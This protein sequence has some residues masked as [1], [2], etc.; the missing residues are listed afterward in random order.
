MMRNFLTRCKLITNP[1]LFTSVDYSDPTA[2]TLNYAPG[3]LGTA[4]ITIRV[5]DTPGLWVEYTF[6]VTTDVNDAPVVTVPGTLQQSD[7]T[8]AVI[9]DVT[10]GNLISVSDDAGTAPVRVTLAATHGTMTLNG[11]AGLTFDPGQDGTADATMTFTGTLVDINNALNGM[12][13]N[14]DAGYF[15]L[16][17][18]TIIVND[19]GN[20]GSGGPQTATTVANISVE[21]YDVW[22]PGFGTEAGWE[23]YNYPAG[24]CSYYTHDYATYWQFVDASA[25]WNFY[26][27]T[28]WVRTDALGNAPYSDGY[29]PY[30]TWFLD[31]VPGGIYNGYDVLYRQRSYEV[32]PGSHGCRS[33]VLAAD[34]R[35]RLVVLRRERLVSDRGIQC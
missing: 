17:D 6:N 23:V 28:A 21:P 1:S 20:T 33:H 2:F 13:F 34:Q 11:V 26:N 3:V 30:A 29:G 32:L 24:G 10:N 22:F 12:S 7:T 9:F 16:A 31:T 25:T 18:V 14:H 4:D 19:Q 15:G 5:T 27:G 8:G 35:R